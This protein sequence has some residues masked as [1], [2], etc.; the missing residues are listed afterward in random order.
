[1]TFSFFYRQLIMWM[2]I[3]KRLPREECRNWRV[4]LC[5]NNIVAQVQYYSL[6]SMTLQSYNVRSTIC[7]LRYCTFCNPHC[8]ASTIAN[9]CKLS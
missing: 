3:A 4:Y 5:R 7:Q 6:Q 2:A 9:S 8:R 1:M